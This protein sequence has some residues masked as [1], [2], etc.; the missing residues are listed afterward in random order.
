MS[1]MTEPTF[2][3]KTVYVTYIAAAPEK[4]WTALTSPE[5]TSQYFFG[6]TIE[7]TPS[8]GGSFILRMPDGRVDSQ[9]KVVEYDPPRRLSVTWRVEWVEEMRKLPECLVTWQVE[10]LDGAVRLTMTEAHQWDVPDEILAGGRTG[11][12][13]ILSSLKSLLE[14]GKP[15]VVKIEP[16]KEM[17]E[18]VKRK[19][20]EAG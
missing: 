9:G 10:A 4:V 11:W 14:T 20:G 15:I 8:V 12:P 6:R 7:L 2:K 1:T 17:L 16:P 5:F 3:P 13:L 19:V 18:A